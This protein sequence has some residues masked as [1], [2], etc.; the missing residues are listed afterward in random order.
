MGDSDDDREYRGR[1]DKFHTERRGYE[2]GERFGDEWR[3]PRPLPPPTYA[4]GF[5]PRPSYGGGG[6]EFRRARY[7][8]ERRREMSPPPKRIRGGWEEER[9]GGGGRG[10]EGEFERE[11]DRPPPPSRPSHGSSRHKPKEDDVDG[12]QPAMMSFK[13]F[14]HTQDDSISDEEGIKKYAEYK[15]EFRRQQLNE[16]FV[17]HKEEEWFRQKYH[18]EDSV[19]RREDLKSM[20]LRRVELFQEFTDSGM[21]KDLTLDGDKQDALM[22][23]LDSVVIKLE[24]GTDF[25]LTVLD[26]P[27][28]EESKDRDKDRE[29][30]R[31]RDEDRGRKRKREKV[32]EDDDKPEDENAALMKKAKEFLKFMDPEKDGEDDKEK[33]NDNDE[34]K[35]DKEESEDKKEE[36][37]DEKKETDENEVKADKEEDKVK[38]KEKE[39]KASK[40][41]DDGEDDEKVKKADDDSDS[42]DDDDEK[43]REKGKKREPSKP[44]SLHKTMSIFLRNL[45]P[46][47]TKLEVETMCKRYDGFLRAAIADPAPDRRWF[48]RGWVTFRR[49]VKIKD[50]CFNLNNIRLK[51]C[52]LGPI[53]NRDLMRRIRTVP[54]L[55]CD[56]K[57]VR[58]DIKL[59]AK[60]ITNLDNKWG[61]WQGEKKDD[62]IGL[63]SSN[64]LLSNITDYLIE[65]ASAEEEELLGLKDGDEEGEDGGEGVT[66]TRDDELIQVL[67]KMILYLRIVHSVDF[68]NHSE[69]P[70]EDEMPNRCGILHA[71]G[72]APSTKVPTKE[73]E[74]Y[75]AGFEKKMGGFLV[76]RLDLTDEEAMKLGLKNEEDEVEKFISANTQELGKDKWLCP[77]SGK[78]FKG[79]DFVQKHIF[80]K[81][82]EKV[83]E[84]KKEVRFFNMYLKDP[85][86]PQL[87][88]HPTSKP[89]MSRSSGGRQPEPGYEY[90][91]PNRDV[92]KYPVYGERGER[93]YEREF[94]GERG[95]R[96]PPPP[97]REPFPPPRYRGN[98][99]TFS[100][101]PVITYRD[102]DAP[103][104][105]YY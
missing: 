15:L 64:P 24:G 62:V 23:V 54:G 89:G 79:P 73:I 35:E 69:Y 36:Q 88:E 99:D 39:M 50:I 60:I 65:E 104:D 29:K 68:Y 26:Y 1:R 75:I 31:D 66:I 34:E 25:D 52:E 53:V 74:E 6:G 33:E 77:L 101:R 105:E 98:M 37:T 32:K 30:D 93:G 28:E 70:N 7:S 27:D 47:I 8:P 42:D 16:F 18:P 58:N 83:E 19:K 4:S 46:T 81:H 84:V 97:R 5:R 82:G 55:T 22:K 57:V 44:R 43:E 100:G 59:A 95:Y 92:T 49:D 103:N 13:S 91:G 87:P 38:E 3:E 51:D 90:S 72:L 76:P 45:A 21:F 67:D 102:W 61:L 71:R 96:Q 10:Y 78:K 48:R 85:K 94:R 40:D 80:N 14:M 63:D 56:R 17:T 20:L 9:Y 41:D 11:F 2:G 12:F 86:R